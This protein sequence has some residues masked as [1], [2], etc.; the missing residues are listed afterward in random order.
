V[1]PPENSS[2]GFTHKEIG[3]F[4]IYAVIVAAIGAGLFVVAPKGIGQVVG[5][6]FAVLLLP[7]PPIIVYFAR[8]RKPAK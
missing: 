5:V 4:R 2:P 8:R 1:T 7:V 6:T 3:V